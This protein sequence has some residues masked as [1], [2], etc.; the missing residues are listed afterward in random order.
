MIHATLTPCFFSF[1]SCI[2]HSSDFHYLLGSSQERSDYLMGLIFAGVFIL[3]VFLAWGITLLSFKC[4]CSAKRLGF[5]SGRPFQRP[6]HRPLPSPQIASG[7][8]SKP[9]LTNQQH[10]E[11]HRPKEAYR[12]SCSNRP[13]RIRTCFIL[14]G[15]LL[16][17]F[18][19]LLVTE[20]LAN[21]QS[22]V[23]V[24]KRSNLEARVITRE[25]IDI[26]NNG[27]VRAGRLASGV[28]NKLEQE[29]S[30]GND[31]CPNDPLLENSPQGQDILNR[32]KQAT[33]QLKSL[34]DFLQNSVPDVQSAL[35]QANQATTE[36][37]NWVNPIDLTDWRVLL[38][39]IPY[40]LVPSLL[41]AGALM[42]MFDV[43]FPNFV[44]CIDWFLMP[45]FVLMVLVCWVVAAVMSIT[46]G[47]NGDFCLPGGRI[48]GVRLEGPG[49][50][51]RRIFEQ[52]GFDQSKVYTVLDYYISQCR[53][54][55]DPFQMIRD[56]G[57]N[58]VRCCWETLLHL[59]SYWLSENLIRVSFVFFFQAETETSLAQLMGAFL[60]PEAIDSLSIHCNRDFSG[61]KSLVDSTETLVLLLLDAVGRTLDLLSCHRI[62]PLYTETFYNGVCYYAPE[63]VRW[64]YASAL[65]M[66]I[67]GMLMITFRSA[68]RRTVYVYDPNVTPK[69]IVPITPSP[70]QSTRQSHLQNG[71]TS[72]NS[73]DANDDD[74]VIKEVKPQSY[75]ANSSWHKSGSRSRQDYYD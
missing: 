29:L 63:A 16:V 33:E 30:N 53:S 7:N 36:A 71:Q 54:G 65:V 22:T 1:L 27:F 38:A 37:A 60:D 32:A 74:V 47:I 48:S 43:S 64:V 14:F 23:N 13:T 49:L 21:L 62:V 57:V 73:Q 20:G 8:A 72:F 15:F 67:F 19:I 44:C 4:C 68:Y 10:E 46:A 6:S 9:K 41:M 28:R 59:V 40:S 70:P 55:D 69:S 39:V 5:L 51:I 18:S 2:G 17:V 45:L 58:L 3:C 66:G 11:L 42:A 56:A 25:G 50:T 34:D 35:E 61:L 26:L 12:P 52:F 75:P 24:L 31:F